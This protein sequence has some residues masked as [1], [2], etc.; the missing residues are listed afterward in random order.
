MY[1]IGI[2]FDTS[3]R[4]LFWV[5][6]LKGN[7]MKMQVSIKDETSDPILLHDLTGNSP[8]GIALDVC[9]RYVRAR[10][11]VAFTIPTSPSFLLVIIYN[12]HN[13]DITNDRQSIIVDFS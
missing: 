13:G 7:I 5:D 1:I 11:A 10:H 2:V 8:R 6:A 12:M 3:T 9:N 4:T